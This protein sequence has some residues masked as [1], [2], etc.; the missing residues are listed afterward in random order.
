MTRIGAYPAQVKLPCPLGLLS[1]WEEMAV[2]ELR[3][4]LEA[5]E[6]TV[7]ELLTQYKEM[8]VAELL[9]D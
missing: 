7:V 3:C 2:A 4:P 1:Q 5:I 9:V 6:V 8:A